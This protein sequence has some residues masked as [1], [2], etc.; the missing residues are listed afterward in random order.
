MR[1]VT[2]S[3]STVPVERPSTVSPM[4]DHEVPASLGRPPTII[5]VTCLLLVVVGFLSVMFTVPA[6]LD[7]AG[8]RCN[9]ARV[10]LD[11]ANTDK[12]AWN[13]V[14][15][16]GR[17]AKDLPCAEAIRLAGQIRLK[18]KGTGTASVPSETALR[19]Q[20]AL[21]VVL[22]L[23]QA[24]SATMV[25]RRLSRPARTAAIAF[26]AFG[27]VLRILGVMSVG[28]FALVV[29]AFA[30]SPAARELWPREPR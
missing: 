14:D 30:F 8:S 11:D 5:R 16:G 21:A 2:V 4:T 20:S 12:K 26:S 19:I 9:L 23:G 25:L 13:N 10:W 27:I 24:I 29:Y 15:T 28:L 7:A 3:T 1:V 22:G 17:K 6:V 18:E